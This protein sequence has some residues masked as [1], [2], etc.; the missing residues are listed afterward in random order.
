MAMKQSVNDEIRKALRLA[1]EYEAER[2]NKLSDMNAYLLKKSE[3]AKSLNLLD[4]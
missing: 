2:K 4:S 3:G 1:K